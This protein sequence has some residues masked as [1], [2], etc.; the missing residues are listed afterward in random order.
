MDN[1]LSNT[2]CT[3]VSSL[4]HTL[5]FSLDFLIAGNSRLIDIPLVR[6]NTHIFD[7]ETAE[8]AA[9]SRLFKGETRHAGLLSERGRFVAARG[10]RPENSTATTL[11]SYGGR[12][13][14]RET[15]EAMS[16]Q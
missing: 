6:A 12:C 5:F 8:A 9:A 10:A 1:L 16:E 2:H 14:G 7:G 3:H 15:T 4:P 13:N 11:K